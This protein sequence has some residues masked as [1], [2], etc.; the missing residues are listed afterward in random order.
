[1]NAVASVAGHKKHST[2]W[3]IHAQ[4]FQAA[5]F[6]KTPQRTN[7]NAVKWLQSLTAY[8]SHFLLGDP[9]QS[10]LDLYTIRHQD[11]NVELLKR[12][13][14]K[15]EPLK[16]TMNATYMYMVNQLIYTK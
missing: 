6:M 2:N 13:D 11:K 16:K 8:V 1:M 3:C 7:K 5:D 15:V 9:A 12:K 10:R 4:I 14:K